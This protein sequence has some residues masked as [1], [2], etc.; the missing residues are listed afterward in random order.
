VTG[1]DGPEVT[2]V[3]IGF[4]P[5]TDC[6]PVIVAAAMG[7]DR[8]HGI[9]I[10]PSREASWAT[11]RDKVVN[12]E[13]DMAHALYGLVY[14]VHLGLSGPRTDMTVLMTINQNGQGLSLSRRLHEKGVTDLPSL[15]ALM[16]REPR[17]YVFAQ[18]FPTGTHA[19]WLYYWLASAGIHP[20]EDVRSIVVPPSQMVSHARAGHMDGFSVGEPWNHKGI[21][22]GVSIHAAASQD[23]WPDHPEKVLGA[24]AD[25]VQSHPNTCRAVIMA[26][27]EACRWIDASDANRLQMAEL[28]AGK[29]YVNT[30]V[31]TISPRILGNYQDGLGRTWHDP[32]H[33]RFHADGAVNFPYLSDGMWFMTQYK[34]WGFLLQHPDYHAIASRMHQIALY[35]EAAE[36]VGVPLP[37]LAMRTSTLIDGVTWNGSNPAEYADQ[38]VVHAA[39]HP[40]AA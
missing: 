26:L 13:L 11:V 3:R 9:E 18:T 35:R 12:G 37:A 21:A 31:D 22:E 17:D 33:L 27:L 38:F 15:K 10:V 36:A 34:R 40:V 1:S 30:S 32:R 23:I 4:I 39:D 14:G 25:F 24:T 16:A 6:A 28:I 7:F 19:M 20:F 8:K 2:R 5:L 29:A